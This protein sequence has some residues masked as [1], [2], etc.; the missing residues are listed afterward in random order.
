MSFL[1]HL[2][3]NRWTGARQCPLAGAENH[4]KNVVE[5]RTVEPSYKGKGGVNGEALKVRLGPPSCAVIN[6]LVGLV[7]TQKDAGIE[8]EKLE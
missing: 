6:K 8:K 2:M 7:M 3:D 5:D 1:A 4:P